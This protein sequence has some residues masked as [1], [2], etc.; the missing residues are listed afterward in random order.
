RIKLDPIRHFSFANDSSRYSR[1]KS[2]IVK[3]IAI[4]AGVKREQLTHRERFV[5]TNNIEK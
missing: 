3:S 2:C 1:W 5:K 4:L